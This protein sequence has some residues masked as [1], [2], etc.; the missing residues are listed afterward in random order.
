MLT[1]NEHYQAALQRFPADRVAFIADEEPVTYGNLESQVSQLC[2]RMR[3]LGVGS[4]SVVGYSLPNCSTVIALLLAISRLGARAVP[5]FPMMPEALRAGLFASLGCSLVIVPDATVASF[6]LAEHGPAKYQVIGMSSLHANSSDPA[7][8]ALQPSVTDADVSPTQPLLAAAS[9]GTTGT[10]KFVWMTQRN[11]AAVITATSDLARVGKWQDEP[12]FSSVMAFPLSTSSVLVVIGFALA[13]VTLVFSN[14]MS[15][16]RFLALA[17]RWNADSLSAPPSYFEHILGLPPHLAP[18]LPRVSA[19]FTGMD[20]LNPSLLARLAERFPA[21]DSAASGYGL[22]ETS[23]VFLTW[24]AHARSEFELKANVFSL[25]PG[26]GNE[27]DVRDESGRSVGESEDGELCVRGPSVVSGYLGRESAA[28]ADGWFHTGDTV[29][30]LNAQSVELRGRQKYLIKRGGKSVSPLEVQAKLETCPGVVASAV[31]GVRQPLYGEMIWAYVVPSQTQPASLTDVMKTCRTTLP[32]YMV[33]D[34]VT[35]VTELPRGSGV[36]K[37]DRE[38]LI[39][40]AML[41]LDA[42]TG[43]SHG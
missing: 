32:N 8:G 38:A 37:L 20:F 27:I 36:G 25:C 13:G 35:F 43:D 11:A 19:I 14:D 21:L 6:T 29:R 39:Q 17:Q 28:F 23:T 7:P 34:R 18:A 41:E 33:P 12:N 16:V 30:R 4:A 22:V 42:T 1:L 9:S 15:P 40:R 3:Q 31:V 26:V 2:G 24:K 10:P 5:L